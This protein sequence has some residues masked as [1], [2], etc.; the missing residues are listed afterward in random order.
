V[1]LL[2]DCIPFDEPSLELRVEI[3]RARESN[4]AVAP[5]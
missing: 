3:I 1:L 5:A 4:F 2:T